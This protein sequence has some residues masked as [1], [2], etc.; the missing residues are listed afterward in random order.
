MVLR[1]DSIRFVIVDGWIGQASAIDFMDS[2]DA[3]T[4]WGGHRRGCHIAS[5][6][7]ELTR[8]EEVQKDS[9]QMLNCADILGRKFYLSKAHSLPQPIILA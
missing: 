2:I 6:I 8:G 7:W 3:D 9:F 1:E 5:R 4:I